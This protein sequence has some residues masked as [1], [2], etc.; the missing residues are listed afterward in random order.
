MACLA[1]LIPLLA[2]GCNAST[3]ASDSPT[4]TPAP[5]ATS[6]VAA[7]SS[8]PAT[9]SATPRFYPTATTLP[10]YA[11]PKGTPIPPDKLALTVDGRPVYLREWER[12]REVQMRKIWTTQKINPLSVLGR[13]A[14]AGKMAY[15]KSYLVYR[16]LMR[17]FVEQYHTAMTSVQLHQ[18]QQQLG[19][20]AN[21]QRAI[22][23]HDMTM[24]DYRDQITLQNTIQYIVNH[25]TYKNDLVHL[26]KIVAANQAAAQKI[27][28][29]LAKGSDFG[30]EARASSIDQNTAPRGGDA[31]FISRL[32]LPAPLSTLAFTMPL[33][34]AS[35][36]F[37][38]G[39]YYYI[40][41]ALSRQLNVPLTGKNL[42]AAQNAYWDQWYQAHL[43]AAKVLVYVKLG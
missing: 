39:S 23:S 6:P 32:L 18:A 19:G 33:N 13:Q 21:L 17:P 42:A 12:L 1:V 15:V 22:A 16:E 40:V 8:S 20:A 36:P 41:K 14:L 2:A 9:F 27:Y 26:L 5:S 31:G 7:A 24:A 37:H 3:N 30:A 10:T 4:A 34:V 43:A 35:Q 38:I 28:S 11:V 29:N 25:H